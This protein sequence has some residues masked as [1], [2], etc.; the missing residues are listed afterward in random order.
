[1]HLLETQCTSVHSSTPDLFDHAPGK[2]C[3]HCSLRPLRAVPH[4]GACGADCRMTEPVQRGVRGA[5]RRRAPRVSRVNHV[6]QRPRS[7]ASPALRERDAG[8]CVIEHEKLL[9][10]G[11]SWSYHLADWPYQSSEPSHGATQA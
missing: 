11:T 1:M 3:W 9:T 6:L 2:R 5:N 8:R 7:P 4:D 10:Q